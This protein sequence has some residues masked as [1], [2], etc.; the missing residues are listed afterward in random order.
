MPL[1]PGKRCL[2]VAIDEEYQKKL[3]G[4]KVRRHRAY[5]GRLENDSKLVRALLDDELNKLRVEQGGIIL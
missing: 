1:K 2:Y 4:V 5:G 3:E